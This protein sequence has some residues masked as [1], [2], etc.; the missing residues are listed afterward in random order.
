M[1]LQRFDVPVAYGMLDL[2]DRR[3][4]A[5]GGPFGT[6]TCLWMA[7]N[8]I[9]A[10]EGPQ[11]Q[12]RYDPAGQLQT[13]PTEHIAQMPCTTRVTE[14]QQLDAIVPNFRAT[15][16]LPSSIT[17]RP[18]SLSPALHVGK[19]IASGTMRAIRGSTA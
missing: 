8:N 9:Y 11:R 1:P 15:F 4:A 16:R 13:E 18:G 2:V 3:I 19:V 12:L 14:R 10:H 17:V 5:A 6:F 7:F